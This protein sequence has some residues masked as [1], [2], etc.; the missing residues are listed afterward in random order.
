MEAK[1]RGRDQCMDA[2]VTHEGGGR[3]PDGKKA[4]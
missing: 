4:S 1:Y 3:D 2:E